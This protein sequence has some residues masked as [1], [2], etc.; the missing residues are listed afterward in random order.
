MAQREVTT[1]KPETLDEII[2]QFYDAILDPGALLRALTEFDRWIGSR[3]AHM[4]GWDARTQSAPVNLMTRA[5]YMHA[6]EAYAQYYGKID[7]RRAVVLH[8]PVGRVFQCADY[9]DNR[10]V[11][12]SEFYQDLLIPNGMRY[13]LGGCVYREDALDIY[14]VFNHAVGQPSFSTQQVQAV[15][16]LMPH[17]QKTLKL[18]LRSESLRAGIVAGEMALASMD[19]AIVVLNPANEVVFCNHSAE[20]LFKAQRILR[21]SGRRIESASF[22]NDTLSGAIGRVRE[23]GKPESLPVG[24]G[25]GAQQRYLTVLALPRALGTGSGLT[26][27]SADIMIVVTEAERSAAASERQLSQL[28]GLTAAEA[29]LAH[30]LAKGLSIE[31]YANACGVTIT[32]ARNQLRAVLAKTGYRRQQDLVRALAVLP[33]IAGPRVGE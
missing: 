16:R 3:L 26:L 23:S 8:Q 28:F 25:A 20:A 22:W 10:Y 21:V 5:E 9:F 19:Q 12:R 33:A 13:I 18:M 11:D 24:A 14:L 15:G 27:A 4:V 29:R 31:E 30:G 2:V 7:P 17:L 1:G 6:G 32:T